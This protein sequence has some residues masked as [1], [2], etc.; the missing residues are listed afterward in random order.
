MRSR[1]FVGLVLMVLG[2]AR[3]WASDA[4]RPKATSTSS[5]HS[6][7]EQA[8]SSPVTSI[9]DQ[10]TKMQ[11][12]LKVAQGNARVA[13]LTKPQAILLGIAVIMNNNSN[14]GAAATF[15]G[16]NGS[17]FCAGG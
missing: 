16:A 15:T 7:D 5:Q 13:P 11:A 10:R 1:V 4:D 17:N 14:D 6:H 3:V 9:T 8:N 12:A 2:T